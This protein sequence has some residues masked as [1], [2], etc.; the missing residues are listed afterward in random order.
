MSRKANTTKT[1][2]CRY[3]RDLVQLQQTPSWFINHVQKAFNKQDCQWP[4][5][6]KADEN[7]PPGL[8]RREQLMGKFERP[9]KELETPSRYPRRVWDSESIVV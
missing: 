9:V 8:T 4:L 1:C 2:I 3:N 5:D 7:L 6:D